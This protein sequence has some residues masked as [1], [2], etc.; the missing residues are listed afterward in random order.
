MNNL[1]RGSKSI[2]DPI[3][4]YVAD[5]LGALKLMMLIVCFLCICM[6]LLYLAVCHEDND[7]LSSYGRSDR[8]IKAHKRSL[9]AFFISG[10][11]SAILAVAVPSKNL[12]YTMGIAKFLT[13]DNIN[14][15][16]EA[17][18]NTASD[19]LNGG[20]EFVEEAIDYAVN[21]INELRRGDE[22]G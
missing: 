4:F 9:K 3:F 20:G 18:G 12:I 15:V 21:K 7:P 6:S 13:P 17:T 22:N 5:V 10:I 11:I 8:Q 16:Y 2:I 14:Y 1:Y 19:I